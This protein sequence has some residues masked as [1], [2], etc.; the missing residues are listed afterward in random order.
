MNRAKAI[1]LFGVRSE[2][3]AAFV[4]KRKSGMK[5]MWSAQRARCIYA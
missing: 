5:F 1:G 4:Q 3:D 2:A